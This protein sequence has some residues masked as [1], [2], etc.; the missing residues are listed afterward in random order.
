MMVITVKIILGIAPEGPVVGAHEAKVKNHGTIIIQMIKAKI[1]KGKT[2]KEEGVVIKK[3]AGDMVTTRN[4]GN[5]K[6]ILRITSHLKAH[7]LIW[8]HHPCP[9]KI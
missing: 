9:H 5:N 3:E 7:I 8:L 4:K 2:L 6:H 1:L